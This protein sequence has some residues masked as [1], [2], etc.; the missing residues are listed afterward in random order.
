MAK[1]AASGVNYLHQS[2]YYSEKSQTWHECIIHRDLKPD[3]LLVTTTY[4]VKLTDFGE[5]RTMDV[6]MTMTQV[7]S[8]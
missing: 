1:D 8:P 7:G 3:N 6:N 4:G 2:T 5:S